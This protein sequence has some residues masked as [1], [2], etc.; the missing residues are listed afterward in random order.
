MKPCLTCRRLVGRKNKLCW[1][2]NA[3]SQER[4]K[5]WNIG[6]NVR[7]INCDN[8]GNT[9]LRIGV[10]VDACKKHFCSRQCKAAYQK[11]K[12]SWNK[13][14]R[15]SQDYCQAMSNARKGK[16]R[17]SFTVKHKAAI[18]DALKGRTR[19]KAWCLAISKAKKGK[20]NTKART[21]KSVL[22]FVCGVEVYRKLSR[23][24]K[25]KVPCCSSECVN[26]YQYFRPDLI[27]DTSIEVKLAN[28]LKEA[29]IG[30]ETQKRIYGV[31]DLF[32]TPNICIFCDGDYYHAHPA[33]YAPFEIIWKKGK[34]ACQIWQRDREV[35]KRL[36]REGYKVLRFWE[37]DINNNLNDCIARIKQSLQMEAI[38]CK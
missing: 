24:K 28:A 38:V 5:P 15:M 3:L 33:Q 37:T 27:K 6:R 25:F 18:S 23:L 2:C 35:T 11:G 29:G 20:P 7:Q 12:P 13:G 22:C 26:L 4:R 34:Y 16:S 1:I 8:C 14:K 31:P 21:G 32:I 10:R 17:G 30:F 19:S 9:L 36:E